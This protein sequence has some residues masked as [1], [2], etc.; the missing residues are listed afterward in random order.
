[1]RQLN[2]EL[3]LDFVLHPYRASRDPSGDVFKVTKP[4]AAEH[5]FVFC[6]R[7]DVAYTAIERI[8]F[9][10]FGSMARGD[11]RAIVVCGCSLWLLFVAMECDK[12]RRRGGTI[13]VDPTSISK[14]RK[15]NR[16]G[17]ALNR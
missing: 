12:T 16:D 8:H 10:P 17:P 3:D 5:T 1:V 9:Y 14:V 15:G 4:F 6:L 7:L 2:I 11:A 13:Y